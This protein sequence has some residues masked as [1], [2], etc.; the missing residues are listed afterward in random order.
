MR[1]PMMVPTM[2]GSM[3]T[4][5]PGMVQGMPG[6]II[7]APQQTII[8]GSYAPPAVMPSAMVTSGS[9]V[10][11]PVAALTSGPSTVVSTNVRTVTAGASSTAAPVYAA[12]PTAVPTFVSGS[13]VPPVAAGGQVIV[14]GSYVPPAVSGSYAAAPM[15]PMALSGSYSAA[16]M[17]SVIGGPQQMVM[18]GPGAP[19]QQ[20][21]L[22]N[23]TMVETQKTAYKSALDKQYQQA[24]SQIELERD[25]KKQ[26]LRQV[27]QQQKDQFTLQARSALEGRKLELDTALNGQLIMLQETAMQHR[28]VLEEKAAALTL[29]FQTRKANEDLLFK[30]YAIQKQFVDNE[31]LLNEEFQQ[32]QQKS[33]V[34]APAK[35]KAA[36]EEE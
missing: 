9:Y 23:P 22:P 5:M 17:L 18:P 6:R 34:P 21:E 24:L 12:A 2:S 13:Y 10:P 8:S 27:A 32:K 14:S 7:S 4:A 30:Q 19:P 20:K 31:R 25:T 26:M 16:P 28:K 33:H 15:A 36:E 29:D 35:A 3:T 11:Q 1:P